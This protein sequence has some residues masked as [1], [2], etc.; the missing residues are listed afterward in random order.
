M[1]QTHSEPLPI[2]SKEIRMSID[3]IIRKTIKDAHPVG[4]HVHEGSYSTKINIYCNGKTVIV[5]GNASRYNRQDNLYGFQTIDECVLVYNQILMEHGL[6]P[7]TKQVGE[8]LSELSR[9][10]HTVIEEYNGA[11]INEIHITENLAVGK[12]NELQFIRGISSQPMGRR[13]PFL[14]SDG[15]SCY[16]GKKSSW[17]RDKLYNKA[18]DMKRLRRKQVKAFGE[19]S[20]EIKY[21]D[22]ITNFCI[23]NGIVRQETEFK[24]KFLT[25]NS[26]HIYGMVTE[27][28]LINHIKFN[29]IYQ[30]LGEIKNMNH[31]TIAEQLINKNIC[32]SL[33]SANPTEAMAM[34][35][36]HGMPIDK[37]KRQFYTHNQR[38]KQ[39]GI[40][41]SVPFDITKRPPQ[42]TSETKI[43][44][45]KIK[46][47][48]WYKMP[49]A[50]TLR[51]A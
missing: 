12:G 9:D 2:V 13:R 21:Y 18:E 42:L 40:D 3:T 25:R 11:R 50:R 49:V 14:Y 34:K 39:I 32:K 24:A 45:S 36:M 7:F 30:T 48:T 4:N 46:P 16:W 10:G 23:D 44:I 31:E 33:Q 38:L 15:N 37:T 28:D 43:T 5:Q 51:A 41:M 47:P 26:H 1:S 19:N 8:P 20:P 22:D 27:S 17:Q 29:D 35:W 6:P